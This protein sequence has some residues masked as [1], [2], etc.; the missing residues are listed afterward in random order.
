[1]N[2]DLWFQILFFSVALTMFFKIHPL[3]VIFAVLGLLVGACSGETQLKKGVYYWQN[4]PSEWTKEEKQFLK[5][6]SIEKVYVKFFEV[7]VSQQWGLEPVSKLQLKEAN[8]FQSEHELIPTVYLRNRIFKQ[9]DRK[10]LEELA[11]NILFLIEKKAEENFHMKPDQIKEIQMDCD[12]T[13]DT[14][15]NYFFFLRKLKSLCSYQLSATLRLYPYKFPE[16]MGILPVDRAMLMCYNLISPLNS[17]NQ[18][19]ILD[20]VELEKYLKG[21]KP[22]PLPLDVALPV[23]SSFLVYHNERFAGM[24]HANL[25]GMKKDLLQ[26]DGPW[27][28]AK[29]DTTLGHVFVR[30]GD[31]LKLEIVDKNRIQKASAILA[32]YVT[33]NQ[34]SV[35]SLFHLHEDQLKQYSHE[36]IHTIYST[37]HP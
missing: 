9:A 32:K 16:K 24:Y 21:A 4:S 36:E 33:L 34:N 28:F 7:D 23:F 29:K 19:S 12:W 8:F 3:C 22:Y 25:S 11:E 37:L 10:A 2:N 5:E 15:E 13:I 26:V 30:K 27:Y 31:R 1:M 6:Q 18:H 20:L 14:Q 17:G 35:L